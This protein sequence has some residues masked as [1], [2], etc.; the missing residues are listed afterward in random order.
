MPSVPNLRTNVLLH[1]EQTGGRVV[2]HEFGAS[3][4]YGSE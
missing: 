3:Q 4:V 1:S 2:G